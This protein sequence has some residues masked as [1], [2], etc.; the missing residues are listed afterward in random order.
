MA[1]TN[2]NMTAVS[3]STGAR[4]NI[5]VYVADAAGTQLTFNPNGLASATSA[6]DWTAPENVIITDISVLAAPTAVG[7]TWTANGATIN[8]ATLRW[9]NQLETLANRIA[10]AVPI[11][12]GTR[13]GGLQF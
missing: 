7:A 2:A 6:T 1:A 13:V 9:N 11:A 4:Y 12:K 10:M 8:G 3:T 5:E